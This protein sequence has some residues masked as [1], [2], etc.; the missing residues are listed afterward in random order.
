MMR[1]LFCC[2]IAIFSGL[3]SS[4]AGADTFLLAKPLVRTT[5]IPLGAT[6]IGTALLMPN[7]ADNTVYYLATD[8]AI[9]SSLMLAYCSINKIPEIVMAARA[10][11]EVYT[12][13]KDRST[14]RKIACND[15]AKRIKV[16]KT[17]YTDP[18][19]LA[20]TNVNTTSF[21]FMEMED[22]KVPAPVDGADWIHIKDTDN[23]TL[24]LALNLP[25]SGETPTT[26][27]LPVKDLFENG[28][29]VEWEKTKEWREALKKWNKSRT[30]LD[31]RITGSGMN[32]LAISSSLIAEDGT[33]T[34]LGQFTRGRGVRKFLSLGLFNRMR[35]MMKIFDRS[36][37]KILTAKDYEVITSSSCKTW[38]AQLFG[39][40]LK[41]NSP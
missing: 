31:K 33:E 7:I 6:A 22:G 1:K 24:R 27:D 32:G 25:G 9:T 30:F 19:F 29:T 18:K 28:A 36:G 14:L 13:I 41:G 10:A 12:G 21:V 11:N 8:D 37:N 17:R 40:K 5:R 35:D 15:G 20:S 23:S 2:L 34:S 3:F 16:L 38:F 39:N 26:I 4:S